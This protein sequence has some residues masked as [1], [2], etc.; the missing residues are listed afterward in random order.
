MF[1]TYKNKEIFMISQIFNA[2][3]FRIM[4]FFLLLF[5]WSKEL[6]FLKFLWEKGP[7]LRYCVGTVENFHTSITECHFCELLRPFHNQV[8]IAEFF[9]GRFYSLSAST[10][11]PLNSNGLYWKY[12]ALLLQRIGFAASL[13][14]FCRLPWNV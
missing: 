8:S 4:N 14:S 9:H 13:V 6:I 10:I 7:N 2:I 1:S 5:W 11:H 3:K 12:Q